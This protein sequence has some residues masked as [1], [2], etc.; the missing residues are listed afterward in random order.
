MK[1]RIKA[2]TL[3][4]LLTVIGII[5][6]LLSLA[7]PALNE[8]RVRARVVGDKASLNSIDVA[9]EAFASDMG[10]YPESNLRT[11][12]LTLEMAMG[13]QGEAPADQGAHRLVE[14]LV[15]LDYLGFQKQNYYEV[16]DGLVGIDDGTPIDWD[17][18]ETQRWGP[19]VQLDSVAIGTM[20]EAHP[21]SHW[22]AGVPDPED[23]PISNP[24]PV[25]VDTLDRHAPKAILYYRARAS[26]HL[27]EDIYDWLDNEYITMDKNDTNQEL[28]HPN[29]S[30]PTDT[31]GFYRFIWD[32]RTGMGTTEDIRFD[33][34]S[35]RPYRKDSFILINAGRDNEYGTVD[36]ICNF[37]K[38]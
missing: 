17:D 15:G 34:A 16:A 21:D 6:L 9:V 24:N 28:F 22:F 33:S 2:F 11:N 8:A 31:E 25:F 23:D 27:L 13:D 4:E 26:K 29:F 1:T 12:R 37:Q 30:D 10:Y 7:L 18:R 38:K 20:Q 36:D 32:T 14:S 35:A 19:Y 5:S 3:V